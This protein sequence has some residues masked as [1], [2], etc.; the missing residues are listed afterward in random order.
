MFIRRK[1]IIVKP[2]DLLKDNES[3]LLL[4]ISLYPQKV[5]EKP[6]PAKCV[7]QNIL[8]QTLGHEIEKNNKIYNK[9][10]SYRKI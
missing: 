6:I 5:Q 7:G 1:S 8:V 4:G 2:L 9:T 10:D 3:P